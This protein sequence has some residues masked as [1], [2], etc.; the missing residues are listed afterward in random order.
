M[1]SMVGTPRNSIIDQK[2]KWPICTFSPPRAVPQAGDYAQASYWAG[3]RPM[4]PD[5]PPYLGET[6]L[7]NLLL[8]V[9]QGSNGWT[10][11]CGCG[12]IIADLV[13]ERQPDID[14]NGLTLD[15]R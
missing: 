12:R 5:G 9:G 2:P 14:L 3:L 13:S 1:K 4:T 11:A 15:G 6:P 10:Q 8:N 7:R